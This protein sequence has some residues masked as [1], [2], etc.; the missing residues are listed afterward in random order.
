MAS[1]S[2]NILLFRDE[3]H[4]VKEGTS[5]VLLQ[6]GLDKKMVVWF[7]GM[8]LSSAKCPRPPGR[9]ENSVW[10][11]IWRTIQ[12]TS[13][14]F[15]SIVW[16]SCDF[17]AWFI[18]T[19]SIWQETLSRFLS[20]LWALSG[21][22]FGN[23][24][25]WWLQMW[26]IWKSWT[27]Q[28]FISSENHRERGID[29]TNRRWIHVPRSRGYENP[30]KGAN[31]P[32]GAKIPVENF[33]VNWENLNQQNWQMTL[34]PVP[35]FGG[36]KVTSSVV[37]TM[38]LEFSSMCRRKKHSL[39]NKCI[40][41][42]RLLVFIWTF[43]NRN[44]SMNT[45]NFDS[46]RSLSDSWKGFT[47]FI[48]LKENLSKDTCGPRRDWQKFKRP[49][50]QIMYD[51]KCEL[52]LIKLLRIERNKQNTTILE[53]WQEFTLLILMTK[54][55]K[56]LSKMWG[57]KLERHILQNGSYWHHEGG[58]KAGNCI[59]KDPKAIYGW[60]VESGESTRLRVE[61]SP[62]TIHEDRIAGK[63][64]TSMTCYNLVHKFISLPQAMKIPDAK[65]AVDKEWK[66]LETTP[67]WQLGKVKSKKDFMLDAQREN[68]KVHFAT[69]MDICHFKKHGVE[70]QIAKNN[71]RTVL[72]GDIV[73]DDS[74]AYAVFSEQGSSASKMTVA[75][76]LLRDCQIVTDKQRTQCQ[77]TLN[78]NWRILPDCFYLLSQNVSRH[79]NTSSTTEMAD[80]LGKH[81]RPCGTSRTKS[82]QNIQLL[83]SGGKDS[84]KT[85]SWILDGEKVPYLGVSVWCIEHKDYFI[86]A[87]EWHKHARNKSRKWLPCGTRSMKNVDLDEPTSFLDHVFLG[88]TQRECK[89]EWYYHWRMY[90]DVWNTYFSWSNWKITGAEKASRGLARKYVE[91]YC[92]LAN[93]KVKQLYKVSCP[94]RDDH[95]VKQQERESVGDLSQVCSQVVLKCLYLARI[96][97][98]DIV[99]S[100]NQLARAVTKLRIHQDTFF[101]RWV[102]VVHFW[103]QRSCYQEG[104]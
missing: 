80:I 85:C 30:H 50:D 98:P 36:S 42:T 90:K 19:F 21:G 63:G 39:F 46:N 6:S 1:S 75:R 54:I 48:L 97:R 27:H 86:G 92:E 78:W 67:A 73:T 53:D 100:V 15:W 96:G 82:M 83:V 12:R 40:D 101:S 66:K 71:D 37:I 33:K 43:C 56:K 79:M 17:N 93:K 61:F 31:N 77:L 32:W 62:L 76:M 69:V 9:R 91:R 44:V 4:R 3:W 102:S 28:K 26:K 10:K 88:C 25:L 5:A 24:I 20:L 13:T 52:E 55:T 95:Q 72:R 29:N 7:Y 60:K 49:P 58:C 22:E 65:A 16:S 87:R 2:L 8:L 51:Q 70:T 38:N 11:A 64:F 94:D 23:E 57:E 45:W 89:T 59:P 18:K 74:W 84:S 68:K 47:R 41:G 81:R 103:R 104:Y 35:T 14:S 34:K 99:W